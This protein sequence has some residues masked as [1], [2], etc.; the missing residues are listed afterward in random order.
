MRME[1]RGLSTLAHED[2]VID[3]SKSCIKKG[4]N[5]AILMKVKFERI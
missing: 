4:R 5:V 3:E 2:E 1:L